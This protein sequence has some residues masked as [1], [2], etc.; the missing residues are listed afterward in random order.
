VAVYDLGS[1]DGHVEYS[2]LDGD[3]GWLSDSAWSGSSEAGS[4]TGWLSA[5]DIGGGDEQIGVKTPSSSITGNRHIVAALFHRHV[6]GDIVYSCV[7]RARAEFLRQVTVVSASFYA[8]VLL[9]VREIPE[10][11]HRA[12]FSTLGL[13]T[14]VS[15][16]PG[17]SPVIE[18]SVVPATTT[19]LSTADKTWTF[20][21]RK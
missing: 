18:V 2:F 1:Q 10:A 16:V 4:L 7:H 9:T 11:Q 21:P 5:T 12:N 14:D 3:E 15:W 19:E 20:G 17:I 8:A 6:S 13:P